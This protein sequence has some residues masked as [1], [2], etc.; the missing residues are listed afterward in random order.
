MGSIKS[1]FHSSMFPDSHN[2]QIRHR[3]TRLAACALLLELANA[4]D[5]F[6]AGERRHLTS[7]VRR[8]FGLGA[9]EAAE[10]IRLAEDERAEAVDLWQFTSL[11]K[12]HYS[13]G[14]KMVLLEIMWGLVYSDG[15]LAAKEETLM[16]KICGL[17]DLEPGY[18]AEVRS[19]M[20]GQE[21]GAP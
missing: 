19:R 9:S 11:I 4:D 12:E 6:T 1:F 15:D 16:R 7:A 3:D 17:L 21:P 18:L 2:P 10:L 5:D 14:Q 20:A 13:R 8:Q